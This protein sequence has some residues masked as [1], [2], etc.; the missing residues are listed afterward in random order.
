MNRRTWIRAASLALWAQLLVAVSVTAQE[1]S[2]LG[3]AA[4]RDHAEKIITAFADKS[5]APTLELVA[6]VG[7]ILWGH[8]TRGKHWRTGKKKNW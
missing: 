6:A 5:H 7:K 4:D 1:Q 8:L 3:R 2:L